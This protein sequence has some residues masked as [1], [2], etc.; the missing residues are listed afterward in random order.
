MEPQDGRPQPQPLA[1]KS[2]PVAGA[3]ADVDGQEGSDLED[4]EI[5]PVDTDRFPIHH[6]YGRTSR[7]ELHRYTGSDPIP[8][9]AAGRGPLM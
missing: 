2:D 7:Q 3:T 6:L 5:H 9:V 4:G 8:A 1:Q